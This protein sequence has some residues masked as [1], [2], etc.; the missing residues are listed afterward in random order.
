ME[1]LLG[2]VAL[3]FPILAIVGIVMAVGTR[4]RLRALEFRLAGI[5]RRAAGLSA[6]PAA[7]ERQPAEPPPEP[8]V[9]SSPEAH[10]PTLE[11][12]STP[13]PEEPSTPPSSRDEPAAATSPAAAPPAPPGIS[14]EERFGTQWV[15]WV[16]G[17]A[18]AFGGFF[19]VRYSIEQGWFGPG[20]RV[21]LGALLA[22]ALIAA[23]EWTRRTENLTGVSGLPT[24]HIPSILT[25][26]GTAVAY[27]DVW[28]AYGLYD[29]LGAGAAFILLGLVALAT[30]AAALLRGPALAGLGLVGAYV[31]PLIVASDRPNYWA[32]YLYLMVV[33]AA[34]FALARA[35]LWRWLAITAVVFSM[36]WTLPGLADYRVD[37]LTPHDFHVVAGF[38]LAAILIV[39]G[40][41]FGPDAT[42]GEIDPVSSAAL[43][44]YLLASTFVVIASD[45]DPL[46]LMTYVALVAAT[47]AISWRAESATAAVPAAAVMTMLVF[48]HWALQLNFNTL[49]GPSGPTAPAIPEPPRVDVGGHL[50]LGTLFAAMFAGT[51]FLAQGR[52]ERAS[53]PMLWSASA[54]FAPIA[55]LVALYYR[56]ADFDRSIPFAAVALLVAAL[57]AFAVEALGKRAPRP[58]IAAAGAIFATGA[59]AALALA[60]TMALEKGWLTVGLALM[61]PGIAWVSE[62]RPL[63]ALRWLAAAIVV[64]VLARIAWEPRIVGENVGSTPIFN[65]ILYGYGIPAA[66]FW[67]A[68]HRLRRRADDVPARM[69]DS[70][71]I[72]FTVLLAFLEIRHAVTGGDVY[73]SAGTLTETALQVSVGLA[74]TIGLEHVRQRTNSI[75]HDIGALVIA[76]LTLLAIVFEL[77]FLANPMIWPISVGGRFINLI[78]LGYG[79]PAV[80][81]AALALQTRNRRP[82]GYSVTAAVV[83][84]GLAL[85]YLTLEVR[86]L[87][88]D[89]VIAAGVTSNAE[90]YTYSAAWLAF[91]VALLAVGI[92]LRAQSVRLASSAV[93]TLTVL[94]VFLIDM[95]DLT[96]IYQVLS[97]LGLG[98]V[99][100]GIGWF[101]QRLL[102]PRRPPPP[103]PAPS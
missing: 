77:G 63:P 44:A 49:V 12:P 40:F 91:G 15:V 46:A 103:G 88:H 47:I 78:L 72:L 52:S 36:L 58:G 60:L 16:G 31:T 21:V 84:V 57:Y 42:P 48:T 79:L 11:E 96:G 30:L 9:T 35:R 98:A 20:M 50:A 24:A 37:W 1:I 67:L 8:V 17:I 69:A 66:S 19:L 3:A 59:V 55:I 71:A 87:Y 92:Y 26:A 45:H 86:R 27:A 29:F 7:A 5:E 97:L 23:G 83:A 33:T 75:V 18:L 95:R 102:F 81:V 99:L 64:L 80:L 25:A 93:V 65:W 10:P 100:M 82:H 53:V 32:L 74:M 76:G 34:A 90:Q 43:A 13:G 22:L 51:G 38:V 89:P 61:V 62:R 4:D 56:I 68:G 70:A 54:V 28:A 94:K 41:L 39:S 6:P 2:L 14:L 101:Y 73:S 85:A